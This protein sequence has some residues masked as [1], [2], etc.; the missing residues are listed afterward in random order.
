MNLE[1]M[2]LIFTVFAAAT[3][4]A[5]TGI[6]FGIIAGPLLLATLNDGSA[7]QISIILNLMIATLLAPTV[8]QQFDS[9][10]MPKLVLGLL[11]GSP[12]GLLIF[13]VLDIVYLK[14][15][16]GMF[17]LLALFFLLFGNRLA[18]AVV[19]RKPATTEQLS[20]GAIA[21]IM[22]GSLAM[23][24]P[25]PAAWLSARGFGKVVTRATILIMFI[26]AYLMALLLQ[27]A[28]VGISRDTVLFSAELAVPT[29]A[30]IVAGRYL[31]HRISEA[32]FRNIIVVVLIATCMTLLVSLND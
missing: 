2:L 29:A 31:S 3:L 21:G 4:Q 28:L 17:V 30:G 12:L 24:G 14:A 25:I 5:A 11:L 15:L 32:V 18:L 16:A 9:N 22:G 6:G 27:V 1:F 13:A 26:F 8:W 20:I 19:D 7:I 10:V 23:P